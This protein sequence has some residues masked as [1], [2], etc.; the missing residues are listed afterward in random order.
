M[1]TIRYFFRVRKW[2]W[3]GNEWIRSHLPPGLETTHRPGLC[4]ED[5]APAG[6]LKSKMP[7]KQRRQRSTI[8]CRCW[9]A[10]R[11]Y[12]LIPR[13]KNVYFECRARL[14]LACGWWR[15]SRPVGPRWVYRNPPR[16]FDVD[17]NSI[18]KGTRDAFLVSGND[19]RST[20]T[21]FLWVT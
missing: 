14:V 16:N 15:W 18:E 17:V 6:Q 4:P 8:F 5:V 13:L 20:P 7:R 12:L 2:H 9:S 10:K 1:N 3:K 11:L 19:S 21:L